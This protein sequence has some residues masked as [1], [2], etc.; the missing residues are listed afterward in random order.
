MF[1][2]CSV[3]WAI[4]NENI[5]IILSDN[6]DNSSNVIAPRI[7]S[8]CDT[9]ALLNSFIIF[10]YPFSFCAN[11]VTMQLDPESAVVIVDFW[12]IEEEVIDLD[13][14]RATSEGEQGQLILVAPII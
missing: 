13:L 5:A 4:L 9:Y 2:K 3:K 12:E 6:E 11:N 8:S 14:K 1:F 10:L 7:V